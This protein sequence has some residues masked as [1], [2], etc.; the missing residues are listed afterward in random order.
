MNRQ[1]RAQLAQETLAILE[2]GF[3]T[4]DNGSSVDLRD[5]IN[6]AVENTILYSPEE[7]AESLAKLPPHEPN[8]TVVEVRNE[9]TLAAAKRLAESGQFAHVLCLNFASAKNPGGGF[10]G[11][12]QAQEES[13][14]RSSAL[15][16]SL[17]QQEHYYEYN[18]RNKT[19]LYS[20]YMIY[21]PNVPV[22]RDDEGYLLAQPYQVSFVTAPA[23]NAG[24]VKKNEPHNIDKIL[25]TL[26]RRVEYILAVAA[27]QRCDA[28]VLGAWGCGVFRNDP[29]DIAK[30]WQ[31]LL[32]DS[33]LFVN[34]FKHIIFAVLDTNDR[35]TYRT[36][37]EQ[38]ECDKGQ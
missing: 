35:G 31:Q 29:Q 20:D 12:S 37:C 14:A 16:A 28:F 33:D 27:H 23:V 21:S 10:L 17:I 22:F 2:Q 34:R 26:Y 36:F 30:M 9:T 7:V 5:A 6:Q 13:L 18:R 4:I 32:F 15:Y 25:P 19:A 24:A 8:S 3:Y 38:F 11:G 1:Q